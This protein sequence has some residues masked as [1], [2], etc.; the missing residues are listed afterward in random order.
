MV[1]AGDLVFD[2]GDAED[3]T[4]RLEAAATDIISSGKTLL[5]LGGDHFVTLPLLRA[6]A[7]NTV[8]WR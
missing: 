4:Q 1:D 3:L 6:H 2:C 5:S 7:K 8:R